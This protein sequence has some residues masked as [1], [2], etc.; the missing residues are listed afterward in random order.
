MLKSIL[1]CPENLTLSRSELSV[2]QSIPLLGI[3][4][5]ILRSEISDDKNKATGT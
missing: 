3:A 4:K 5:Y 1:F 2:K